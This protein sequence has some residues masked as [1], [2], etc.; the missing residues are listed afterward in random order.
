MPADE[1]L[2]AVSSGATTWTPAIREGAGAVT[3]STSNSPVFDG[4][5]A[6]RTVASPSPTTSTLFPG[7]EVQY[8]NPSA[9]ENVPGPTSTTS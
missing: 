1:S 2:F 5:D 6:C 4:V 7:V 8:W 3:W 9:V